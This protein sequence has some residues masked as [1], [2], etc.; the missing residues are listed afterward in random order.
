MG[1][2]SVLF[3]VGKQ[4]DGKVGAGAIRRTDEAVTDQKLD[5]LSQNRNGGFIK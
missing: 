5:R 1:I 4:P 3:G 2:L